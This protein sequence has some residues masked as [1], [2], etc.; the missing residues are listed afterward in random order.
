MKNKT[1]SILRLDPFLTTGIIVSIAIALILIL[2]GQ[3]EVNSLI[4]GLLTTIVTILIDLIARLKETEYKILQASKLGNVLSENRDLHT[5]LSQIASSYLAIPNQNFDKFVEARRDVLLECK[6]R[7]L[8][9]EHGYLSILPDSKH[10][11]GKKGVENAKKAIDAVAYEDLESWRT[12]HLKSVVEENAN[13]VRRGITIRRVFV[14]SDENLRRFVDVLQSHRDAG[15]HI[16]V[17]T[18]DD[19]PSTHLLESFQ[20]LDNNVLVYFYYT[21]DGKKFTGEKISIE[22][23]EVD[24]VKGK[25]E[26]IWN[27][28]TSFELFESRL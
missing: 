11:Y 4:A 5:T 25:F 9:M 26:I 15:V 13:A 20:I 22:P 6:E 3:D 17:A 27:R 24:V 14:A 1:K 10:A 16:R 28:A 18:P 21:R 19:L 12:E 23:V 8:G 7:L 2:L